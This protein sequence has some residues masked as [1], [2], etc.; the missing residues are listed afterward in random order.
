[1]RTVQ[2]LFIIPLLFLLLFYVYPLGTIT[3]YSFTEHGTFQTAQFLKAVSSPIYLKVLWFT[4]WQAGLSTLL[5]LF[6][7]LPGAWVFVRYTFWGKKFLQTIMTIPFVMP[8]V[9]TATAFQ[10]MLGKKGLVNDFFMT[11]FH[12]EHPPLALDHTIIFFLLAHIFYN[13]SLVLRIVT[14]YWAGIDIRLS[15]A[16]QMLGANPLYCFY[17]ITLPLLLPAITSAALLVFIFCFTSFG[18]IL[19]LGGPTHS[20]LEVEIYRQ[21]VQMFNLPMA[22]SLSLVQIIC[23]LL[24]MWLHARVG[25]KHPISFFGGSNTGGKRAKHTG[26]RC[27]I[28]MT[29]LFMSLLL[30]GPMLSLIFASF[31]GDEGVS[32]HYYRALATN[33]TASFFFVSP[34]AAIANSLGFASA[35]TL[36]ALLIG[37]IS[38][39]FL[40]HTKGGSST[41]WDAVLM[42][43]LATSAVTLGFGYILTLN[44]PPLNLHDSLA[45]LPVAHSMVASP[46][47]IRTMLPAIRQIPQNLRDAAASLGATPAQIYR[48]I[49]LPILRNTLLVATI[50]AFS[51]SMGEFG[52]T[53]FLSRPQLPTLPIAIYRFLSQPGSLSYGQAMALATILMVVTGCGFWLIDALEKKQ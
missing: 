24:L 5:T 10:A 15:A 51:I 31:R 23:N 27:A 11:V 32:L 17:K 47:V 16:A 13:Y 25:Q 30:I 14:S 18:I 41:F 52:A 37:L 44:K 1:M 7:A 45:L 48:H 34:L 53:S 12:L 43:P 38:A 22:A 49:E 39:H 3:H 26:D 42:L 19:I 8:T 4:I 33:E 36:L 40:F 9:V 50:F 2:L 35:A 20:T 28:A 29:V 6:F 21:A 46:F